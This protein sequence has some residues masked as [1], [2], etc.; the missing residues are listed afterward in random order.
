M[1]LNLIKSLKVYIIIILISIL[2]SLYSFEAFLNYQ[3]SANDNLKFKKKMLLQKENKIYDERTTD[4]YYRYLS[5]ENKDVS[6][7]FYP[8]YFLKENSIFQPLSGVSNSLTINCNENGYISTYLSDRY[9]FNNP[10]KEW[11]SD[12]IE[13]IVIGDSFAH[14]ACVNRPN[15]ISSILR[16]LTKKKVLN[17]GYGHNGPLFEYVILREYIQKNTKKILWL[18]YE[19]NDQSD[20]NVELNNKFLNYYLLDN[21]FSQKLI[22]RQPEVDKLIKKKI[23]DLLRYREEL[24]NKENIKYKILK[25]IRLDKTKTILRNKKEKFQKKKFI[26][27]MKK[28]NDLAID[29]NSKLYFVYLPSYHR[30]NKLI[31]DNNYNDFIFIKNSMRDLNIPFIDLHTDLISKNPKAYFPFGL[32]GHY[33]ENGYK[34]VGKF[35]FEKTKE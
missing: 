9:G 4:Q 20:L 31:K 13:Y 3:K 21:K 24:R 2:F 17:L 25:F 23:P 8:N 14:G 1:N 28:A 10:D 29:N 15:D 6:V 5:N 22:T 35:L 26:E 19:G 11:D 32:A 16:N 12:E 34:E 33:N 30:Y 27:I 18:Y 7:V